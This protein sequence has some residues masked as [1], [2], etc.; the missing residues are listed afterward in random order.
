MNERRRKAAHL[1]RRL[2]RHRQRQART[3]VALWSWNDGRG[4]ACSTAGRTGRTAERFVA[5][6]A[7]RDRLWRTFAQYTDVLAVASNRARTARRRRRSGHRRPHGTARA[8]GARLRMRDG[9]V[10]RPG[11]A[12]PRGR[13][14]R[15]RTP[16]RRRPGAGRRRP[17]RRRRDG[18][19]GARAQCGRMPPGTRSRPRDPRTGRGRGGRRSGRGAVRP[20]GPLVR[21]RD[22]WDAI[23]ADLDAGLD[24]CDRRDPRA[25]RAGPRRRRA[26]R[27]RSRA[28]PPDRGPE[29]RALRAAA[30]AAD[31]WR[32][33]TTPSSRC[34]SVWPRPAG[35]RTRRRHS[36]R[37]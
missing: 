23:V 15:R 5:A 34:A 7:T 37:S 4:T 10:V 3:A 30:S 16:H 19:D 17:G 11:G 29:L 25:P 20:A 18:P 6:R 35:R 1:G 2:A 9:A 13:A 36:S 14:A 22:G 8:A 26:V 28:R 31:G 12:G 21:L 27:H 33:A 32:G 24:V